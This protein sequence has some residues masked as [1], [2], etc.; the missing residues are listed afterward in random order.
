MYTYSEVVKDAIMTSSL[1]EINAD[2]IQN[3][4]QERLAE[5]KLLPHDSEELSEARRHLAALSH[6]LNI[7]KQR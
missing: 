3:G 1:P 4:M 5:F 7:A 2:H 6:Q